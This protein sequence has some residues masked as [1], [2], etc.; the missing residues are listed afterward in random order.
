MRY[1]VLDFETRSAVSLKDSSYRHYASHPTTD[2]LCIGLKWDDRPAT[3]HVPVP[4]ISGAVLNGKIGCTE[5]QEAIKAGCPI[6]AHNAF[7]ERRIYY[8]ICHLRFG[9]PAIPDA[10]W[11]DT[12]AICAYYTIPM[13]LAKAAKALNLSNLKDESAGQ[14]DDDDEESP[15]KGGHIVTQ[16][17]KPRNPSK[18]AVADWKGAA[19]MPLVWWED[20][21]RLE[22]L[23]EYCKQDVRTQAELFEKLGPLPKDRWLDWQLDHRINERGVRCDWGALFAANIVVKN[24]LA[25][26]ND[27]VRTL[28]ASLAYPHGMVQTVNERQNILDWCELKGFQIH[29]LRKEHVEFVLKHSE[30]PDPVRELLSLR[31]AAG[32]TSLGKLIKMLNL[33]DTDSRLR[34]SLAWHGAA[35]GRWA[36]RAWQPHNLPRECMSDEEAKAFHDALKSDEIYAYLQSRKDR[37]GMSTPDVVSSALRS[38]LIAE[39]GKRLLVSDFSSIEARVLAWFAGCNTMLDAFKAEKCVYTQFASRATGKA[40]ADITKKSRDR[41]LGKAAVL[42]LGYGMGGGKFR[43][44]AED[45]YRVVLTPE[46]ADII[47]VLYRK[48]YPEV[49]KLWSALESAFS[50]AILNRTT[51]TCGKL[52]VGCNGEWGFIVLPSKRAIW[53]R[54]PMVKKVPNPWRDGATM[55]EISSMGQNMT[56][57]WVRQST[58][59]GTLVE[60]ICQA[61]AADLLTES[62]RRTENAGYACV[63]SVHDE[64]IAESEKDEA[65]FHRLMKMTPAWGMDLPLDCETHSCERYGK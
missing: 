25:T 53:Y 47:K 40:E 48:T 27:R 19:P 61:T 59:G 31:Q 52:L 41:Q 43:D 24:S 13:K 4:G 60:N 56:K 30:M 51:V 11:M 37:D 50:Q 36:G 6:V 64:V 2:I 9:W 34:D 42:G 28:T 55:N 23:Y 45:Q 63:L 46:E 32:K 44:T 26:Y 12:M 15:K 29:S 20:S 1:L 35:T 17:C 10:Q 14:E 57:Q 8:H 65:E 3:V 21:V 5:I 62:I 58:W 39:P 33:A 7:F 22:K 54:E 18:K 16:V 38:F 49:P